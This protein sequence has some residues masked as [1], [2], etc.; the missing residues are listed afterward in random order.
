VSSPSSSSLSQTPVTTIKGSP[1]QDRKIDEATAGLTAAIAKQLHSIGEDN[2][3]TIV[4]YVGAMKSEVNPSDHYRRDMI[5]I[6]CRLSKYNNNIPFKDVTR[7]TILG[8]LDSLRKTETQDPMHKWIG[9]YNLFRIHLLRFFKWLYSPDVE[10]DKRP[11]P[12]VFENIA[13]L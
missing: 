5:V 8:F 3:T 4:K 7:T 2:A 9:T 6:I 10:P 1:L 12:S 13:T 11:K